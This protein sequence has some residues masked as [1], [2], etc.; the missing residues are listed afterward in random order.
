MFF[1]CVRRIDVSV[2]LHF[3]IPT[4]LQKKNENLLIKLFRKRKMKKSKS[5]TRKQFVIFINKFYSLKKIIKH[6]YL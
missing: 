2:Y 6:F 4:Y 3:A 1:C 5:R